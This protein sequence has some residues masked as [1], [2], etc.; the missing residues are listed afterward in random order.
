MHSLPILERR[1]GTQ[2]LLQ[3]DHRRAVPSGGAEEGMILMTPRYINYYLT[4][5]RGGEEGGGKGR[6]KRWWYCSCC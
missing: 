5:A 3:D 2:P 4:I 1:V 6:G